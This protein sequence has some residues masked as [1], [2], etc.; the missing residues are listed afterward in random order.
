MKYLRDFLQIIKNKIVV[1]NNVDAPAENLIKE[2]LKQIQ[3]IEDAIK[4]QMEIEKQMPVYTMTNT[5][6]IN[7]Y[8]AAKRKREAEPN[9]SVKRLRNETSSC[10][11]TVHAIK[12]VTPEGLINVQFKVYTYG[13][14]YVSTIGRF[15]V[16]PQ[17]KIT[18]QFILTGFGLITTQ[19]QVTPQAQY[20]V[21]AQGR[22]QV[23]LEGL[24]EL[25]FLVTPIGKPPGTIHTIPD[26]QSNIFSIQK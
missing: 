3:T 23:T 26:H 22:F 15:E 1:L 24:I 25:Q 12:Q 17:G 2:Y 14:Y 5:K 8:V 13:I 19:F 11:V 21:S 18:I 20:N 7:E 9:E 10:I 4:I 16:T 6:K